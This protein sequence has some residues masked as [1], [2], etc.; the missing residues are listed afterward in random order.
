MSIAKTEMRNPKSIHMDKMSTGEMA[1]LV[2]SAN[3]D[4]VRAVEDAAE[5]IALAV[6]AI[7]EAFERGNRLFY[8]GA[9]TSGRLGVIDA[10]D[11]PPT[12][13]VPYDMVQGII[14]GGKERMFTAGENA[15]DKYDNGK[16]ALIEY[17]V[18]GGDVV[19]G[20]SAAGNAAYVLG[21]IEY[22]K[23]LGCVTVGVSSNDGTLILNAADIAIFTDTGAEVLTGSTR[24]KAGTAQKIVLNT[25]TTCAMAK[26]GKVYENMMIN[27]APSNEKLRRRVIRIVTEILS[28]DEE[29]AIKRLEENDW[30]IR[31]AVENAK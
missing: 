14:A 16:E 22:A 9:G 17:G 13:G 19:V 3:Y 12:F 4:A 1:R 24:L 25:L 31:K 6:D 28:C 8:V 2:I 23:S 26:T 21:A 20:I 15:E 30:I 5:S 27:L 11:C 7:A 29:E 18:R 10:S